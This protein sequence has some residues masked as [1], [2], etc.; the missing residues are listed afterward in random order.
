MIYVL[1]AGTYTPIA[2]LMPQRGWGWSLFGIIWGLSLI[3]IVIKSTGYKIKEWIS[4]AFYIFL[5][6]L[7]IVPIQPLLHW[8]SLE[9]FIWLLAGGI[10]YTSGCIFFALEK[11]IPRK[12]WFG[13]HEVFH[14]FV[15]SGSFCHF[16][17]MINYVL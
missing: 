13:M 8:L 2:L 14:L 3:G 12:K 16:W 10:F 6:W 4:V 9:A 17:L 5:G 15:M 7:A 11:Y 1:I